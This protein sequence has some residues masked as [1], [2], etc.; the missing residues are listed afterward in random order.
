MGTILN[1]ASTYPGQS[2]CAG[3]GRVQIESARSV[4]MKRARQD[5]YEIANETK[6]Q[7]DLGQISY[8]LPTQPQPLPSTE[9]DPNTKVHNIIQ[10]AAEHVGLNESQAKL[11]LNGYDEGLSPNS[12]GSNAKYLPLVSPKVF[13]LVGE[14][15]KKESEEPPNSISR[16]D[17]DQ[18]LGYRP[19]SATPGSL[20]DPKQVAMLQQVEG[21]LDLQMQNAS[22]LAKAASN[23]QF[24]QKFQI[25]LA[26]RQ[27]PELVLAT[28]IVLAA[29]NKN[30]TL[31]DIFGK[32]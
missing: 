30:D 32:P 4:M 7:L 29:A 22:T 17:I 13:S 9:P 6:P 23:S 24:L 2:S 16:E 25:W 15:L 21:Q 10:Y 20:P 11:V 19:L 12:Q 3:T 5:L 8:A 18:Q 26:S 28:P 1:I 27:K 14:Q 31:T